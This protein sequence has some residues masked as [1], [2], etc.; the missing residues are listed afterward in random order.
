MLTCISSKE[1]TRIYVVLRNA[2]DYIPKLNH[3]EVAISIE[4]NK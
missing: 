3:V 4:H 2:K 1:N